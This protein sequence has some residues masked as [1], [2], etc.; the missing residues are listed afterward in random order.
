MS[1]EDNGP[2]PQPAP[3]SLLR[4]AVIALFSAAAVVAIAIQYSDKFQ[5]QQANGAPTVQASNESAFTLT[6]T[7]WAGL[8]LQ[9]AEARAFRTEVVTDGKIAIDE[10][11]AT[12]VFSPYA[13]QVRRLAAQ[14][15]EVVKAGQLL[16]TI[17]ATDM[18]QAQNDF[19]TAVAGLST[20]Q[21]QL[22][23]SQINEQRQHEL[24]DATAGP[25]KDWQQ[26]QADLVAA[27]N[28]LRSAEIALEA[29]RNRLRILKKTEPEIDEFQKTGK[30]NPETPI[31]A[32]IGGAVVQRKVGP[33]QFITSGASDPTGDP[34]FVIGDLST[35]WL[36]ANVREADA[37][38]VAIGQDVEF[39]VL[40]AADRTFKGRVNFVSEIIDANTRRLTVRATIP[41]ADRRL[42]PEMF[43]RVTIVTGAEQ[44]SPA[45]PTRAIV[46]EGDLARVWVAVGSKKLEV[47]QIT[48]GLTQDGMVQV[49][50]GLHEG[51]KVVTEG[52]LFI[53]RAAG[54]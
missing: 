51:E 12:P 20:A 17:E 2:K 16:F 22:K 29:V 46:Y 49:L 50:S 4:R 15:G 32:P 37:S 8:G 5:I 42:K 53:D 26:A 10:N 19:I 30:I 39:R 1:T 23:L 35:V 27:Q 43:A 18:V 9:S 48:P 14:P 40:A 31:F 45:V 44:R 34:V 47:R 13:G 21:S 33:G 52:T 24:F 11:H 7:Q 6:D 25:L 36:L 54:G 3:G 41:N 38:T 28:N